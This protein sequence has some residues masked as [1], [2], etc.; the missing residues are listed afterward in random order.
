MVYKKVFTNGNYYNN[1]L[2]YVI[3]MKRMATLNTRA[4]KETRDL[5]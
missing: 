3:S 4:I 5:G 2:Y 1:L